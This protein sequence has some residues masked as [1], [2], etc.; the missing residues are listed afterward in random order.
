MKH[1]REEDYEVEVHKGDDVVVI[2]KPTDRHYRFLFL[3]DGSLNAAGLV[4]KQGSV[5]DYFLS[6]VDELARRRASAAVRASP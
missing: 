2:F 5:G 3:A 4:V 1:P 6:E